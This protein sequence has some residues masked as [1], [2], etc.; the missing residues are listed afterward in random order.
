MRSYLASRSTFESYKRSC[1]SKL[2]VSS[3][4]SSIQNTAFDCGSLVHIV[5]DYVG[6]SSQVAAVTN[7]LLAYE[8]AIEFLCFCTAGCE[9]VNVLIMLIIVS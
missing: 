6:K 7:F 9:S 8:I 5:L 2:V 4:H 3:M 1:A